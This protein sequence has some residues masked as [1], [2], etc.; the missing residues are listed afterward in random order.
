MKKDKII[1]KKLL[2]TILFSIIILFGVFAQQRPEN[3]WIVG[4]WF[5][6]AEGENVEIIINDNGTGRYTAGRES[7]NF[8][9][10]INGNQLFI[11]EPTGN[12]THILFT[13]TIY[14]INDQRAIL[15]GRDISIRITKR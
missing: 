13:M 12:S 15:I 2:F 7:D 5:G 4:T 8:I 6:T 9:F 3:R 1:M 14:R 10:S 11:F